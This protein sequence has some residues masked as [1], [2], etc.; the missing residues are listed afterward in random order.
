MSPGRQRVMEREMLIEAGGG[1][2][3]GLVSSRQLG[4]AVLNG[5]QPG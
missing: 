2:G 4:P 3:S 5:Q 1:G